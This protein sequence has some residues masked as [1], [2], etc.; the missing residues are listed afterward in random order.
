MT[1]FEK[2]H[3]WPPPCSPRT[4]GNYFSSQFRFSVPW[5]HLYEGTLR[6]EIGD[7]PNEFVEGAYLRA[8]EVVEGEPEYDMVMP[9]LTIVSTVFVQRGVS[10]ELGP[11]YVSERE[12]FLVNGHSFHSLRANWGAFWIDG[13][14]TQYATDVISQTGFVEDVPDPPRWG[15]VYQWR[16]RQF[17]WPPPF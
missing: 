5:P 7:P 17:D 1:N 16:P 9:S 15:F 3:R 13:D 6:E 4:A 2:I 14:G 12:D 8:A 11:A 10:P